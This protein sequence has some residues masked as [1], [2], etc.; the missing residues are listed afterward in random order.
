[1]NFFDNIF[2]NGM[3][4]GTYLISA[5]FALVCGAIVALSSSFKA[6]I[7]KSFFATLDRKSVV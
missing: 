4:V 1:M 3:T 5:V 2:T 7:S 6:R